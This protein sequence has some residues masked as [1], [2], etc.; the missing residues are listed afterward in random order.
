MADL[1]KENIFCFARQTGIEE[2]ILRY[3]NVLDGMILLLGIAA[4]FFGFKIY[5]QLFAVILFL[6]AAFLFS[7]FM[8]ESVDWGAVVTCFSTVGVLLAFLGLFWNRLGG[9][10]ICGLIIGQIS[11]LASQSVLATVVIIFL[12]VLCV[13]TFPVISICISTSIWGA[14][15]LYNVLP[16]SGAAGKRILIYAVVTFIGIAVQFLVNR[17]QTLFEKPYPDYVSYKIEQRKRRK[18]ADSIS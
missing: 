4:C 9:C 11:W 7:Y 15:I 13:L 17:Q 12:S 1:L 2:E 10:V 18:N 14:M 16:V 6:T 8:K 3:E 5:R